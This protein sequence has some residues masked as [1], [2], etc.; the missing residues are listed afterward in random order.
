MQPKG[1]GKRIRRNS[2]RGIE[3]ETVKMKA[4]RLTLPVFGLARIGGHKGKN[5]ATVPYEL[6]DGQLYETVDGKV[7]C[8]RK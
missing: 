7:Y 4:V 6:K 5:G 1:S 2:E 8:V 3:M